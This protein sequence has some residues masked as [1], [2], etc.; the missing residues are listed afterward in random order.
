MQESVRSY[1]VPP[2]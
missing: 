2:Y 1:T